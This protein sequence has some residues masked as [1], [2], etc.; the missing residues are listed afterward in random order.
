MA[1]DSAMRRGGS[2]VAGGGH[3]RRPRRAVGR[4][5]RQV[6]VLVLLVVVVRAGAGVWPAAAVGATA[7]TVTLVSTW[8]NLERRTAR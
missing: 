2:T 1:I 6:V 4:L 8:A 7:A 3:G 5:A